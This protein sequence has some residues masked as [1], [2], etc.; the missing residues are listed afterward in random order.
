M[1][2]KSLKTI[3]AI[4]FTLLTL[5][6][7]AF[8][9]DTTE[10]YS[11]GIVTHLEAY[12]NFDWNDEEKTHETELVIGGGILC[13]LSYLLTAEFS[14]IAPD[15][16]ISTT[17]TGGFGA[18]LIWTPYEKE[19]LFSVDILPAFTF[20]PNDVSDDMKSVKP[21]FKGFSYGISAELNITTSPM[22]QPYFILGYTGYKNNEEIAPDE[23]DDSPAEYPLTIGTSM[24]ATE[25][26]EMLVQLEWIMNEDTAV[27]YRNER[28]LTLG[29]NFMLKDNIELL[30][31]INK[32]YR[33][34][35][36]S[37]NEA[38]PE[39]WGLGIGLIYLL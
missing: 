39:G 2:T 6:A 30:T 19:N 11:P 20:E 21:D 34:K 32:N 26:L 38:T 3:T 24:P 37:G 16:G 31:E 29:L 33:V 4:I 28:Y 22:I 8:A 18:G 9:I 12:Y 14:K 1:I 36:K 15:E 10:C 23:Y 13:N 25:R 35:D 27:F 7:P 17:V 5:C